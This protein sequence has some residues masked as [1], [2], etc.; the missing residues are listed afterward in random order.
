MSVTDQAIED[1]AAEQ[2]GAHRCCENG[3]SDQ[4]HEC[5]KQQDPQQEKVE[6][7]AK[8]IKGSL[9]WRLT[10]YLFRFV[11][12]LESIVWTIMDAL[13]AWRMRLAARINDNYQEV[14]KK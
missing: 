11:M 1:A 8:L 5:M 10:F 4:D 12:L 7:I 6:Y 14:K 3:Y 9:R 2:R 13:R